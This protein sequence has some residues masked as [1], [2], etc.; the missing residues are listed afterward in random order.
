MPVAVLSLMQ[1]YGSQAQGCNTAA[2]GPSVTMNEVSMKTASLVAALY[3]ACSA[4]APQWAP[5]D[6]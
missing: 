3:I 5:A 2:Q 6:R 1:Q 4:L